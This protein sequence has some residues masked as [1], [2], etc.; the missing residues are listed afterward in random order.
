[1]FTVWTLHT[2]RICSFT[3]TIIHRFFRGNVIIRFVC[4]SPTIAR[5]NSFQS[6]NK[7][8]A[9]PDCLPG[10][11]IPNLK[12]TRAAPC[13]REGK[14]KR[15]SRSH[16]PTSSCLAAES[17][18]K[19]DTRTACSPKAHLPQHYSQLLHAKVMSKTRD[20]NCAETL[21]PRTYDPVNP[22]RQSFKRNLYFLDTKLAFIYNEWMML[23]SLYALSERSWGSLL[24]VVAMFHS[25]HPGKS[26]WR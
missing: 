9:R 11:L 10:T 21:I 6:V 18:L 13:R 23:V 7:S 12:T 19:L 8:L 17:Y 24:L 26:R 22:C 3:S 2:T 4:R 15:I 16:L 1:M 20:M 25:H 5:T 14:H